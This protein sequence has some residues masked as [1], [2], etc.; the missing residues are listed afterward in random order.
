[1]SEPNARVRLKAGVLGGK[2]DAKLEAF[3]DGEWRDISH[4]FYGAVADVS[5][6][7][8]TTISLR[9]HAVLCEVDAEGVLDDSTL[10]MLERLVNEHREAEA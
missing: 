9:A 2:G 8:V 5:V 4:L 7:E 6:G 10:R 3:V 1:M